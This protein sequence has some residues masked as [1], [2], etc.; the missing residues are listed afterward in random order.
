MLP[1]CTRR[2]R[3]RRRSSICFNGIRSVQW[4]GNYR[5]EMA[6]P[7][8]ELLQI[9]VRV[10]GA[11]ELPVFQTFSNA[12]NPYPSLDKAFVGGLSGFWSSVTWPDG[13]TFL[14]ARICPRKKDAEQSAAEVAL[15]E[16]S[17]PLFDEGWAIIL[18]RCILH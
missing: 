16:V 5:T 14:S 9:C 17:I 13:Q 11:Q 10:Y 1:H 15:Q 18:I 7:K 12:E 8:Q 6:T 4:V 3:R 2:R